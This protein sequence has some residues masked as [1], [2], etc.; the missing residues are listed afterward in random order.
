MT[1]CFYLNLLALVSICFYFMY[2]IGLILLHNVVFW[3]HRVTRTFDLLDFCGAKP[4]VKGHALSK[5][6]LKP[7][8]QITR[9]TYGGWHICLL[10][11]V[12][13]K[14]GLKFKDLTPHIISRTL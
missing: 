10:C 12:P 3:L 13:G 9:N 7:G 5:F 8:H 6:T 2:S 1:G 4:A 14:A 11:V